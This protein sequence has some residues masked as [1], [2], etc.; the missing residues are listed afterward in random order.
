MSK[1]SNNNNSHSHPKFTNTIFTSV[2]PF[3]N[4]SSLFPS[5][6]RR[7]GITISSGYHP[8]S[9]CVMVLVEEE[10]PSFISTQLGEYVEPSECESF[11]LKKISQIAESCRRQSSELIEHAERLEK[12]INQNSP[13]IDMS[14]IDK[15][16]DHK[17]IKAE[18][19]ILHTHTPN[20]AIMR[21][22]PVIRPSQLDLDEI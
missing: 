10:Q 20:K 11:T 6:D 18:N 5:H 4:S 14:K 7:I 19:R 17:Q 9:H 3:R 1:S 16:E 21:S 8:E 12:L 2:Q 13:I 22:A 15:D